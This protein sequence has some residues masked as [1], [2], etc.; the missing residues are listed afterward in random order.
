MAGSKH[1]LFRG[2]SLLV[3]VLLLYSRTY[4]AQTGAK[5][6]LPWDHLRSNRLRL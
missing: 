6:G 5:V 3:L 4:A 2:I 1:R